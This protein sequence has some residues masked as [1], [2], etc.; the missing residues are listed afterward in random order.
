MKI[1]NTAREKGIFVV[2]VDRPIEGCYNILYNYTAAF[3]AIVRHIIVKHGCKRIS[4]MAGMRDNAFSDERIA[5]CR[6]VMAEHGL[7]LTDDDIMYGNFWSGPTRTEMDKLLTSGKPLPDAIICANDSM[8]M[9]VCAKLT[10][11]GYLV[12]KDVIVTGFDGIFDEQ[13]HIPRLTTAKQ[14]VELAG[15]K[16]VDAVVAHMRGRQQDN[17]ALIDHKI[18]LTHS[19]GCKPV[20]YREASGSISLLFDITTLDNATDTDMHALTDAVASSEDIAEVAQHVCRYSLNYAMC[21]YSLC[22][23]EHFMSISSDYSKYLSNT[24][25]PGRMQLVLCEV[26]KGER[27]PPYCAKVPVSME[28]ALDE[29]GVLL[30]F[31]VHFQDMNVGYG[32]TSVLPHVQL[33]RDNGDLKRLPKY[34]R[35]LNHSLEIANTQS[36]MRKVI[37]ELQELYVRDHTGLYNRRGFYNEISRCIAL[38]LDDTRTYYMVIVSVDMDGLKTINDT[39]G[40]SEGDIAIRAITDAMCAIWGDN[41]ICARFGGDEFIIASITQRAPVK[42]SRHLMEELSNRLS[43]FNSSSGKPYKVGVSMGTAYKKIVCDLHVDDLIKEADNLMYKEKS[44]HE[45]SRYS[46]T[47]KAKK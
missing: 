21:Y 24:T 9:A 35:N 23:S 32:V 11:Y 12:P 18:R 40:H 2:C 17:F 31:P 44:T 34:T 33:K 41:E 10:E 28:K 42:H 38:A 26:F 27:T 13:F 20:D 37:S 46:T 6:K 43:E 47:V 14:D 5:S 16:A 15:E 3:E 22:I 45:E 25:D 1:I 29:F 8:A 4:M 7:E 39:Y 36:V 19:C 30:F